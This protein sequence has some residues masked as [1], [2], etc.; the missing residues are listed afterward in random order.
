MYGDNKVTA[1]KDKEP[2]FVKY[3]GHSES[4]SFHWFVARLGSMGETASNKGYLPTCSAAEGLSRWTLAVLLEKPLPYTILW[5]VSGQA[6]PFGFIKDA[7]AFIA[8]T[9]DH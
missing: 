7:D 8:F 6:G 5:P 3:I 2:S 9:D 4:L 1:T